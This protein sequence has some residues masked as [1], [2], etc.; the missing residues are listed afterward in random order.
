[1]HI[2]PPKRAQAARSQ[3]PQTKICL[4]R[5]GGVM[6]KSEISFEQARNMLV[7]GGKLYINKKDKTDIIRALQIHFKG[8]FKLYNSKALMAGWEGDYIYQ[9]E[10][11]CLGIMCQFD[12]YTRY[13]KSDL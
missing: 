12:F 5:L 9:N 3:S 2:R 6:A 11:N 4:H 8:G 13:L 10:N 7:Q 1:V